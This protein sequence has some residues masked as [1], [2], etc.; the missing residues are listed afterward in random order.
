MDWLQQAIEDYYSS[1]EFP[2]SPRHAQDSL[3]AALIALV[4]EQ[5]KTNEHLARI[6]DCLNLDAMEGTLADMTVHPRPDWPG[7]CGMEDGE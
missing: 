5:R 6:A 7:H 2:D 1:V 3:N 4:E